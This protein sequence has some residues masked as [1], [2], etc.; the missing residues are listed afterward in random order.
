ML[1][2][3]PSEVLIGR[4]GYFASFSA[5]LLE[6]HLHRIGTPPGYGDND[7]HESATDQRS[8]KRS[9]IYLVEAT[10]EAL[11]AGV[12]DRYRHASYSRLNIRETLTCP[13]ACAVQREEQK[14]RTRPQS[15]G[16]R[17]P[18]AHAGLVN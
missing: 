14:I 9:D 7:V 5:P 3:S 4:R 17:Y 6:L 2:F 16:S 10:K 13:N 8:G 1:L 12:S 15:E 11:A 18:H